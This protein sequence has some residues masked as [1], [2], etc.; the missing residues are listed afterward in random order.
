MIGTT[1]L[2]IVLVVIIVLFFLLREVNC[3]YWKINKGIELMEENNRLLKIIAGEN[4]R[5][6]TKP[7][8]PNTNTS[9]LVEEVSDKIPPVKSFEKDKVIFTDGVQ[10]EVVKESDQRYYIW[11]GNKRHYYNDEQKAINAI[12]LFVTKKEIS[13]DGLIK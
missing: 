7:V 11:D 1:E 10:G 12:Y 9:S 2:I 4:S 8:V 13:S 3:W 6:E 5:Q